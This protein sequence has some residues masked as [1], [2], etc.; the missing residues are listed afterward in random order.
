MVFKGK[1]YT[2][3]EFIRILDDDF[4]GHE[5]LRLELLNMNKFGNDTEVDAYS[6]NVVS[7]YFDLIDELRLPE[8]WY[9]VGG[10]YSLHR[11][12]TLAFD[13]PATPDGRKAGE[14]YSENQS[15]AYGADKS[16]VT[17]LLNSI[18]K[19]PFHRTAN[20][21]LNITFTHRVEPEILQ[22]LFNTYFS[23]GGL[24]VGINMLDKALLRD[25]MARPDKHK[26]LTVRLFG[27]SEYFV[28][29]PDW[30][31]SAVLNRTEY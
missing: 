18:A 22:A 11:D 23:M 20:G 8:N 27:F 28:S 29:L 4:N 7:M 15:P 2:Y 3:D 25:A 31:Q 10:I 17:A 21:G 6:V 24:H 12:N 9:A 26:S 13:I 19:L 1:R 14:A 16:G 5:A 30:Q